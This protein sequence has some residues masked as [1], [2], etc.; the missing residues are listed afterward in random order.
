[1]A[2]RKR[3]LVVD[4]DQDILDLLEYN[5][6]REGFKI[7]TTSSGIEALDKLIHFSPDLIILDILMPELNGIDLCRQI[8]EIHDFED[9]PIF[10]LTAHSEFYFQEAAFEIGGDDFIEKI[11]GLRALTQKVTAVL[12]RNFV[13]RKREQELSI[14]SLKI[15][16][17]KSWVSVNGREIPL[18]KPELELLFFFAQNPGRSITSENLFSNIWGSELFASSHTLD[19]YLEN[20]VKK[21]GPTWIISPGPNRYQFSKTF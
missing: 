15:N 3:V 18:S 2:K 11:T 6:T 19:S 9:T 14:G 20:L 1:M 13:I 10:F 12:S 4:D 8:R 21:I 7:K 17:R 5:L 16:R